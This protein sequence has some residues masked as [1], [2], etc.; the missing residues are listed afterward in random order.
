LQGRHAANQSISGSVAKKRGGVDK[1][2]GASE[3][4]SFFLV[5]HVDL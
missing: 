1:R 2:I 4:K 5:D 3:A